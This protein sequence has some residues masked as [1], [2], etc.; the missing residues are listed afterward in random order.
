MLSARTSR[1]S[2]QNPSVS[3]LH[4]STEGLSFSNTQQVADMASI[5]MGGQGSFQA[6]TCARIMLCKAHRSVLAYMYAGN[7]DILGGG[8]TLSLGQDSSSQNSLLEAALTRLGVMETPVMARP[9][10]RVKV[11]MVTLKEQS[12]APPGLKK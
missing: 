9:R 4:L 6:P 10:M 2:G 7:P 1:P 8:R 12:P 5:L 3:Q 11:I